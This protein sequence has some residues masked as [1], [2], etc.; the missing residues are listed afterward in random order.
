MKNKILVICG[1]TAV[2]KTHLAARM[3]EK[4]GGE[5]VSADSRQVYRDMNIGTGKDWIDGILIH[6]YDLVDPGETFSVSQ[7]FKFAQGVTRDILSRDKLP[8]ITGGTGLY[9]KSLVDGIV[10]VDIP[11]NEKLR[12]VLVQSAPS[13]L[14]EKLASLDPIK[15]ASLNHSDK[16]NPRRLIRAIEI[17]S[18]KI[19]NANYGKST[20]KQKKYDFL[21]LG[22]NTDLFILKERIKKRVESRMESGFIFEVESLLK[23]GI[24]WDHQAMDSFGYKESELFLKKGLSYEEFIDLWTKDEIKYA[25]RQLTWFKKDKRIKWFDVESSKYPKN[26]EKLVKIWYYQK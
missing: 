19:D 15:A 21:I 26:V 5:I 7:Y 8:I 14:F 2:G 1:P 12:E 4:F 11:K 9:I 23:K 10:T 20:K 13:S 18:W 25:K 22:L 17:A 3:A 6:G 24:G 16:A